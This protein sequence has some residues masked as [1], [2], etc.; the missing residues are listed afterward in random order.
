MSKA[1]EQQQQHQS[2]EQQQLQQ[3]QQIEQLI[4][5]KHIE[6]QTQKQREEARFE[7]GTDK[8]TNSRQ[9]LGATNALIKSKAHLSGANRKVVEQLRALPMTMLTHSCL[10][11]F[12]LLLFFLKKSMQSRCGENV[13]QSLAQ[14]NTSILRSGNFG[15]QPSWYFYLNEVI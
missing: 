2:A 1:Q 3:M 5:Q 4:L 7:C 11:W 13:G 12:Y 14:N 15:D 10:T 6:Q 8:E 9:S